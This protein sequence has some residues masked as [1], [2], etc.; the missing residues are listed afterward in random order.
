MLRDARAG[1]CRVPNDDPI[2]AQL[3][4]VRLVELRE[5]E[6]KIRAHYALTSLGLR[7]P[8]G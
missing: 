6:H 8:T 4:A 2:W 5:P 3:E 7:Y 1:L